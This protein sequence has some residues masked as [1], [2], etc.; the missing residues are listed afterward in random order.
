MYFEF[1]APTGELIRHDVSHAGGE[2]RVVIRDARYSEYQGQSLTVGLDKVELVDVADSA[3]IS[4]PIGGPTATTL[5]KLA[6]YLGVKT[7]VLDARE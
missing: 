2:I 6:S 5:Q 1:T 3:R 7:V 4:I